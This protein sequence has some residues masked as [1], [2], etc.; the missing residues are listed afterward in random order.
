MSENRTMRPV[1]IVLRKE[2]GGRDKGER[3]GVSTTK[4]IC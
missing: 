4:D 2:D 3:L 1:E